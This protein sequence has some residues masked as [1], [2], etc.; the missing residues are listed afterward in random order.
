MRAS[1]ERF[2]IHHFK[3]LAIHR[4][5]RVRHQLEFCLRHFPARL[6]RVFFADAPDPGF[7][8]EFFRKNLV[9]SEKN[10][11]FMDAP[12]RELLRQ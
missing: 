5:F 1:R 3:S 6:A 11:I 12:F 9:I 8:R 4:K 7:Y 10:I 2:R